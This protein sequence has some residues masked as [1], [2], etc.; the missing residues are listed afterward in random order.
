MVIAFKRQV[1]RIDTSAFKGQLLDFARA[2]CVV[3]KRSTAST[4]LF[5]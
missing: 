2:E 1:P 5:V 3:D 4:L